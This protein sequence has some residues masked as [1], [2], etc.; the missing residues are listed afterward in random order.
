[1]NNHDETHALTQWRRIL[2][3]GYAQYQRWWL[4]C[5][6]TPRSP[7]GAKEGE[8]PVHI[9]WADVA[10]N[11]SLG[12]TDRP[13]HLTVYGSALGGMHSPADSSKV[14]RESANTVHI[15]TRWVRAAE[16]C[17]QLLTRKLQNDYRL[18]RESGELTD[19]LIYRQTGSM[20]DWHTGS[21]VTYLLG[22]WLDD[23]SPGC[24]LN[25]EWAIKQ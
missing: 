10:G 14:R 2:P 5:D 17:A 21:L 8:V 24:L 6:L 15:L 22:N 12:T 3:E 25:E 11:E 23:W 20:A 9:L 13:D 16:L 19:W 7:V 18:R 4:H 1:M